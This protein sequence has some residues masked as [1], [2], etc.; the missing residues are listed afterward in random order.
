[1]AGKVPK[2]LMNK[3]P[4]YKHSNKLLNFSHFSFVGLSKR[5]L[6]AAQPS[7]LPDRLAGVYWA[8]VVTCRSRVSKVVFEATVNGKSITGFHVAKFETINMALI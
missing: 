8:G 2:W 7:D 1:M 5:M 4:I 6:P 3:R